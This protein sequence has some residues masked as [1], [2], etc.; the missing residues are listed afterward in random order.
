MSYTSLLNVN[1]INCVKVMPGMVIIKPGPENDHIK[2]SEDQK[3]WIDKSY[4]PEKHSVTFG[5]IVICSE[6]DSELKNGDI[7]FFHYLCLMNAIRDQKYIIYDNQIYYVVNVESIFVVKRAD[8]IIP[9][10]GTILC[11][12]IDDSLPETNEWGM[13]IP[14]AKRH[15]NHLNEGVVLHIG[16]INAEDEITCS[17]GDRVFWRTKSQVP[18]QYSLF[19]N[20]SNKLIYQLKYDHIMG[21]RI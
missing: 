20:F 3:V 10:N 1:D 18:L 21:V 15:K 17:V 6:M 14:K 12:A 2:I 7:I 8:E 13:A 11:E 9:L 5:E 16:Q 4:E 19:S